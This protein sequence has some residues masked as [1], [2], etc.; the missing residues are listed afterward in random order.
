MGE[1]EDQITAGK[2]EAMDKAQA[3]QRVDP[4]LGQHT[5]RAQS[6]EHQPGLPTQKETEVIELTRVLVQT[7]MGREGKIRGQDALER[8]EPVVQPA[9]EVLKPQRLQ[10]LGVQPVGQSALPQGQQAAPVTN[11]VGIGRILDPHAQEIGRQAAGQIGTQPPEHQATGRL[12][13]HEPPSAHKAIGVMH[14]TLVEGQPYDVPIPVEQVAIAASA[15][16]QPARTVAVQNPGEPSRQGT[17]LAPE[18]HIRM[19]LRDGPVGLAD[20]ALH[21]GAGR[22]GDHR[23]PGLAEI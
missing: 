17:A 18:R 9:A 10:G 11:D 19:L 20:D 21:L 3:I 15:P 16:L 23:I 13:R 22:L 5:V 12:L 4:G 8:G 1:Q 7:G 2:L 14:S 6:V